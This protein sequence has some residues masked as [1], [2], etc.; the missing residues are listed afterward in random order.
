MYK[1][2]VFYAFVMAIGGYYLV[3]YINNE[4]PYSVWDEILAMFFI[5]MTGYMF[6]AVTSFTLLD[7][8]DDSVLMSLKITPISVKAYV[9]I[10]L[11]SS[12]VFGFIAT[13][14]IIYA[15]GFLEGASTLVI[16]AVALLGALQGPSLALI[17]NSFSSNKVEGFVV[18]KLSG[19]IL[20]F[21]VIAFFVTGVTQLILGI[22]PGYWP[23]A[24]IE[25]ELF[26]NFTNVEIFGLDG[27]IEKILLFIIGVIYNLF[28]SWLLLKLYT[29][30]A[31]L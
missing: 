20:F 19:L 17:V 4:F 6:G 26:E 14:A 31:N 1:F 18:M 25:M 13:T 21:P 28:A 12:M 7:D 29:K 11:A 3:N 27:N 15:T 16:L 5:I 22:A 24:I 30:K 8:K 23:A 2:F 9:I 10:K